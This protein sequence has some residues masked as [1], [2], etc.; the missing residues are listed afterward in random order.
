[1]HNKVEV[2]ACKTGKIDSML[3]VVVS[4]HVPKYISG[5]HLSEQVSACIAKWKLWRARLEKQILCLQLLC[6]FMFPNI[7]LGS[8]SI[9][10]QMHAQ[11]SGSCGV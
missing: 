10:K 2:V 4:I 9:N 11:Q 7:F 8:T 5:Q 6:L 3:T 1:M